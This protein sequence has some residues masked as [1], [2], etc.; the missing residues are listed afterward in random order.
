MSDTLCKGYYLIA[1]ETTFY[2]C[3]IGN[4]IVPAPSSTNGGNIFRYCPNCGY[5]I[6]NAELLGRCETRKCIYNEV[7][8][9]DAWYKYKTAI[10]PNGINIR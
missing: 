10:I 1:E 3:T 9:H 7:K 2:F 8:I 4:Y 5:K 6:E